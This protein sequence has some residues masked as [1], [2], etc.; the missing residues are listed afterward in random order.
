[1]LRVMK[2]MSQ[3]SRV[4]AFQAEM[5]ATGGADRGDTHMQGGFKG[6]N[7][8]IPSSHAFSLLTW[9]Y[10]PAFLPLCCGKTNLFIILNPN[11]GALP[12]A[13]QIPLRMSKGQLEM[14]VSA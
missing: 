10:R 7:F 12:K 8:H 1:M 13:D 3:W 5:Y 6:I 9:F 11:N 4:A 2:K 14:L